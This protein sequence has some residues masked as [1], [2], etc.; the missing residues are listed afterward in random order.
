MSNTTQ[1]CFPIQ[2]DELENTPEQI[3]KIFEAVLA[4]GEQ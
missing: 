1:Y 3:T 2:N 4:E